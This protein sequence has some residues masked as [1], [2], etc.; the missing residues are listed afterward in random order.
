MRG[1]SMSVKLTKRVVDAAAS[2]SADRFLWDGQLKGF[3]LKVTPRGRKVYIYQY[4]LPGRPT[5]R[6][7]VGVHGAP[8]TPEVAREEVKRLMGQ[9]ACGMDP[10]EEKKRERADPTIGE[11]CELYLAEGVATKKASTALADRAR[12]ERHIKP[13]LGRKKLSLLSRADISRFLSDVA[14]GKTAVDERTRKRGR[15]IVKGGKIAA[16]RA[17]ATLSAVLAFAVDRGLRADNPVRGVQK[18]KEGKRERFLSNEELARLGEALKKAEA[19]GV[20]LYAI[21]AIRLLVLTG[22]RKNEI[23]SLRWDEVDIGDGYLRL[24]DSKTGAKV[25]HLGAPA[26]ALLSA[27]PKQS[28]NPF[29]ICGDRQDS[30]LVGLQKIWIRIRSDSGLGDVRLHDLRHSFASVAARSGESLLVIG[31]V[32]GH[33]TSAATSRYAHLSDDPV[34]GAAETTAVRISEHLNASK[35]AN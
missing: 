9:V 34:R 23:L 11:V 1:V 17:M 24:S 26:R 20:N 8:W 14:A 16:N 27:L 29:V 5:R 7:T 4:R 22:C 19:D 6:Y 2:Q 35:S 13:L 33:S 3:G 30:H 28:G 32:L 18:F 31:K 25:V 15:A 10:A 21:A 12:I